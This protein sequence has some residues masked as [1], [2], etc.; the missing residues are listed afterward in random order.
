MARPSWD[1]HWLK[2][3]KV[4]SERSTCLRRN[5]GA[6]IVKGDRQVAV[7][8]NGSARGTANCCDIGW[9][10]KDKYGIKE[11]AGYDRCRAGPLH[12]ELNAI[13][14]A[15]R[16]GVNISGSTM[17]ISGLYAD[18]KETASYPCKGCQ[19]SI[20]NSGIEKVI[21]KTGKGIEKIFVS[22]WT[23]E[24]HETEDRDIKGY[25]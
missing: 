16:E 21:I 20:I 12:A 15:A 22:K 3:A 2:I 11:G 18:G 25:Y 8:Y 13:I 10:L 6:V 4:V 14:N 23:R 24:A 9:C 1:E 5:F 19:K 7:G 17:Y